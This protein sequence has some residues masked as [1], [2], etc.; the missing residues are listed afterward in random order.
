MTYC[1]HAGEKK[2]HH[3]TMSYLWFLRLIS[4]FKLVPLLEQVKS[5]ANDLA[6]KSKHKWTKTEISLNLRCIT[7]L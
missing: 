7:L 4:H 2:A 6:N 5:S 1:I 3:Q